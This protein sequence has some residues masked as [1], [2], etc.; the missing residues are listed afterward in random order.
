MVPGLRYPLR[1][2]QYASGNM[3]LYT[4]SQSL[5]IEVKEGPRFQKFHIDSKPNTGRKMVRISS[6]IGELHVQ[7]GDG[8]HTYACMGR[9][10]IAV[11]VGT[12]RESVTSEFEP[13][14]HARRGGHV[15][16]EIGLSEA[17]EECVGDATAHLQ[18]TVLMPTSQ[19][20]CACTSH[21]CA[22]KH[23]INERGVLLQGKRVGVQEYRDHST[24]DK[25][26]KYM[27]SPPST[28]GASTS[29]QFTECCDI[30]APDSGG[31]TPSTCDA[32]DDLAG[33]CAMA[34]TSEADEVADALEGSI[35]AFQSGLL[36]DISL[37]DL[38]FCDASAD[39]DL[40]L[41]PPLQTHATANAEFLQYQEWIMRLYVETEK[42]DCEGFERCRN[43]K[44]R[45]LDDLRKEWSKLDDLKSSAWRMASKKR[46]TIT[47]HRLDPGSAQVIDTCEYH[48]NLSQD[49]CC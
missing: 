38:V 36:Q 9:L 42:L 21:G 37:K 20:I 12:A 23:T 22:E 3:T 8:A 46:T 34:W 48:S 10:V 13:C 18:V 16:Y 35:S 29:N 30:E 33:N 28:G 44:S 17:E 25:R 41:P 26:L 39:D 43:M 7:I 45:F 1:K 14:R 4:S 19:R 40:S 15:A 2:V 27:A 6:K 11:T 5:R 31:D 47:P 32:T 24:C 49:L